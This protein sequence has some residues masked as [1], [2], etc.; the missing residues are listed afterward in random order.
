MT[1]KFQALNRLDQNILLASNGALFVNYILAR[2]FTAPTPINQLQ[3]LIE[4]DTLNQ[5]NPKNMNRIGIHEFKNAQTEMEEYEK[6]YTGTY[7]I[8]SYKVDFQTKLKPK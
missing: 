7:Y 8:Y 6:I 4:T 2:Y 5:V 3:W 1:I